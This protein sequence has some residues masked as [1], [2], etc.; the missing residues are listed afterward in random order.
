MI[1]WA[2]GGTGRVLRA[3]EDQATVRS[4]R[5]FAPGEPAQGA[6]R[7]ESASLS[8]VLK[9]HTCK[10][11]AGDE[12][13]PFVAVGKLLSATREL[14]DRFRDAVPPSPPEPER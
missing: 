7:T 6:L 2:K 9:V 11:E 12:A 10:R 5:P 1:E 3:A 13:Q 14:R 4:S 8:F